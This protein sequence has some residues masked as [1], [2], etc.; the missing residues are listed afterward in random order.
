[1]VTPIPFDPVKRFKSA[2][3]RGDVAFALGLMG[4]LI[5]LMLPLPK[6]LLDVFLALSLTF[7][8]LVL[9]TSLFIE[10]PLEFSAFPTV[11][12]VSTMLRLALNVA[13]TRLILTNGHEGP[14]AAGEVIRAFGNF[15]MSGN[16]VIGIIVFAILVIVNFVVITKGSGRIAEVSARFSL[17]AMPGKQMAVDADLS[18]GLIN[19]EQAKAR[20]KELEDESNFYGAMDGAAKFVRG[21]AIAGLLITFIN[22]VAGIIIGVAQK[23]LSL[24]DAAQTY[25]LLTVGDGLVSQIPALVVSTAAGMLVSKAGVE[26]SAEKALFSQLGAYPTA[27][28]LSSFLMMVMSLLPGIPFLP[29]VTL[30]GITGY[31][32]WRLTEKQEK[33]QAIEA[34]KEQVKQAEEQP[35]EEPITTAL[36]IDSIRLELGY[37]LLSLVNGEKGKRLTDQI[38]MLRRQVAEESGFIMP[39]VR[40]QDNLQLGSSDYLI[41]IKEIEA[42]RGELRSSML[43]AMDPMGQPIS[44]AGEETVEPAFGLQAKW[45]GHSLREE[46]ERRGYTVVD[47]ITV[48][49]THLTEAVRD[50]IS[51]LLSYADTQKLLDG[52]EEDNKK[53]VS[54]LIPSQITTGTLQ[55]ILQNLLA[56]RVSI[57]DLSTILEGLSEVAGNSLSVTQ[58]TEHVRSRLARQITSSHLDDGGILHVTTLSPNWEQAFQGAVVGDGEARQLAMA[59]SQLQEFVAD[60]REAFENFGQ[61]GESPIILTGPSL[62]PYVRSIVERF[63]PSTVVMSQSEVHKSAK[64]RNLGPIGKRE[65]GG[66]AA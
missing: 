18:A 20:R 6:A 51:D 19:E 34:Q 60:V 10:K 26:G 39:S 14:H 12:L 31:S 17:D 41:R 24:G 61:S 11:L 38:K 28:G 4:V 56:E 32:A 66:H 2:I 44:L 22:V 36:N 42:A 1:M 59:P 46:A 52:L 49:T 33:E 40:I 50:N 8:V 37:G 47:A 64:I 58:M 9:M 43:L 55:R 48:L 29:F 62:R 13:S 23:G 57:R 3:R 54:D 63:R 21:D 5:V 16:F 27:L 35:K 65:E 53:L 25:T 15:I 45:I 30:S 7:S